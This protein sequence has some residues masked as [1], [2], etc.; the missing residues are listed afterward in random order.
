MFPATTETINKNNDGNN[1]QK[2]TVD[3][4]DDRNH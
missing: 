3:D 1:K 4:V 2:K